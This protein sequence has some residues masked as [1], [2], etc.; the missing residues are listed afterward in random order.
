VLF[1]SHAAVDEELARFLKK[2][3]EYSFPDI[4][5]FVSSDPEDLPI[6][7][8][9]VEDILHALGKAK[10][11]LVL[12]TDRSL[13]RR[14]VWF[15][16]GA[17]WYNRRQIFTGCVGKVRKNTLQ[18]PF[19][20]HTARNLDEQKD[21][22]ELFGLIRHEF[23]VT[24]GQSVNYDELCRNLVRLDLRAEMRQEQTRLEN[25]DK[26]FQE[27]Q[28]RSFLEKLRPLDSFCRDLLRF[29]L[30]NGESS[31]KHVYGAAL[32][33][34]TILGNFLQILEK[35][36]LV[37]IRIERIGSMETDR[38]WRINPQYELRLKADLFPRAEGDGPPKFRL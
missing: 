22:E 35:A 20:Q 5:V 26:A 24:Q 10:L 17:G 21:C 13:S 4:D 29:L 18:P 8:P 23:A 38:Y 33:D 25:E 32:F 27:A 28:K 19:G 14:W 11:I 31:G 3:V 1:V 36:N 34:N 9:W 6:G 30:L 12:G 7:N 2:W 37:L 15:E 16:A